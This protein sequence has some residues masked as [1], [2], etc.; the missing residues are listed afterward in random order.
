MFASLLR[1]SS[2]SLVGN[3][4]L[5]PCCGTDCSVAGGCA[6]AGPSNEKLDPKVSWRKLGFPQDDKHPVVCVTWQDAQDY[7]HWLSQRTGHKYRLLSEAGTGSMR[8]GR[9]Q[10]GYPVGLK[11]THEHANYGADECCS[12]SALL[13][14]DRWKE[15]LLLARSR[16][17]RSDFTTCTAMSCNR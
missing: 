2:M 12:G 9:D 5:F 13:R 6:W 16:R 8:R 4:R 11:S 14:R 1:E 17:T 15:N 7:V 10:H 3:G